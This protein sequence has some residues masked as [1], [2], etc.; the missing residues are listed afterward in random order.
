LAITTE[1]FWK[2]FTKMIGHPEMGEDPR[3][4]T[5]IQRRALADEIDEVVG[6][7]LLERTMADLQREGQEVWR[8]PVGMAMGPSD[9]LQDRHL[10]ERGFWQEVGHPVAG[11]HAYPSSS[12]RLQ[13]RAPEERRAPLLGE[14]ND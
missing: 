6:P 4:R 13:G 11:A 1:P 14:H 3:F 10:T 9:L 2:Q 5:G 8:V 7:W 12:F